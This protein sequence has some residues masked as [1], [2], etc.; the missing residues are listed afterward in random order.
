M[1]DRIPDYVNV[2]RHKTVAGDFKAMPGRLVTEDGEVEFPVI[3][4]EEDV[5]SVV[6]ALSNVMRESGYYYSRDPGHEGM[7]A[8][9][10]HT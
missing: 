1:F 2:V 4:G 10:C 3:R 6:S 5:L 8:Y 7:V 9:Y